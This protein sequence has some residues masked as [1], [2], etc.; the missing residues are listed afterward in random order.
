[1]LPGLSSVPLFQDEADLDKARYQTETAA[2]AKKEAVAAGPQEQSSD[3]DEPKPKRK[4]RQGPTVK[5]AY[6][7]S[8]KPPACILQPCQLQCWSEAPLLF[9]TPSCMHTSLS[10]NTVLMV[11]SKEEQC[12]WPSQTGCCRC[13][14][15]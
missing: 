15:T 3:A 9:N 7:V 2:A 5:S 8:G 13:P 11:C 6:L 14:T 4:R 10:L 12:S 1:M